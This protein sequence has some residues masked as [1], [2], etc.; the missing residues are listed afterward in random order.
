MLGFDRPTAAEFSFYMAIPVMFGASALKMVKMFMEGVVM[1][2]AAWIVLL[3]GTLV[4]FGVSVIVIRYL[5][6][7]IRKHDFQVFG[8]YRIVLGVLILVL[9]FFKL[10]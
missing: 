10:I 4:S 7:Y 6:A 3:V 2:A 9:A 5:M 8:K 1:N